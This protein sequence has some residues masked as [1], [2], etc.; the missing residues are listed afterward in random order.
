MIEKISNYIKQ[1]T[2]ASVCSIDGTGDPLCFNCFYA[3][4]EQEQ[5]LYFKSGTDTR[6]SLNLSLNPKVGGTIL[7][8]KMNKFHIRGVQFEGIVLLSGNGL[9]AKQASGRYY[10]THPMALAMPGEIWIVQL[11]RIKF[12]DN[13]LGFGKKLIWQRDKVNEFA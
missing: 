10:Q 1:Q 5:L 6:H 12:T 9:Q 3:Y 4:D 7:P 2:C 8:D 11:N 13:S